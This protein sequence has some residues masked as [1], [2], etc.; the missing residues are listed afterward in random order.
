MIRNNID[1]VDAEKP[2][3]SAADFSTL[4]E[5]ISQ[6]L[7]IGLLKF[8]SDLK[9]TTCTPK[10]CE[11]IG[12]TTEVLHAY[13]NYMDIISHLVAECKSPK[14]A[15]KQ[16]ILS[17]IQT[18]ITTQQ[19][20][21]KKTPFQTHVI[22]KKG[23][24]LEFGQIFNADG[25]LTA[26]IKDK[27][28][29]NLQEDAVN[30]AMKIGRTGYWYFNFN[31]QDSH[32][33]GEYIRD[34]LDEDEI[35]QVREKGIWTIVH[36]EDRTRAKNIWKDLLKNPTLHDG[37][38]RI[39]TQKRGTTWLNCHVRPQLSKTN[40]MVGLICF[41]EDVTETLEIQTKL[42]T[43]KE[44]TEKI[45]QTKVDFL[46]RLS[47]EI[48]TPLNAVI[49]L[50]DTL[51]NDS[52]NAHLMPK[53][54]LIDDSAKHI[55]LLLNET[56]DHAK[57]EAAELKLDPHANSPKDV[58]ESTCRLWSYQAQKK[59]LKLNCHVD[60]SVPD[61]MLFD[62]HRYEQCLNNL[63]SNAIKFTSDGQINVVLTRFTQAGESDKLVLAVKDNGIGMSE[64]QQN[65][66][67]QAYV[68]ADDSISRRFGGTGLGLNI[69]KTIVELM[70]GTI[71]VESTLGKGALFIITLPVTPITDSLPDEE[72]SGLVSKIL[73]AAPKP[74]ASPYAHL[75]VLAVDD[76]ATNHFVVQSLL[77]THVYKIF[78]ANNG[79][80]ALDILDV[81]DIDIILM[82]IH[83]PVMDGVEATLAIRDSTRA[84]KDVPIIALTADPDYQQKRMCMNIGMN[85][86]LSK[87]VKFS[88]IKQAFETVLKTDQTL[89]IQKKVA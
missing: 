48:R 78:A 55:L 49:G 71:S 22:T 62:A 36:P 70:E 2:A 41:F 28:R 32:H 81:E 25:S 80:E 34:L 64:E 61:K 76:N 68:Q 5:N 73:E 72:T 66:V 57:L 16:S 20:S 30:A 53:L 3:I 37:V 39:R 9:L 79:Q 43:S 26:L 14:C 23:K 38:Y 85:Y 88:E 50:T 15:E 13:S 51:V 54:Q 33:N 69:T 10:A 83:M 74:E 12:L 27:S 67:F 7:D 47:H 40:D 17:R 6:I 35:I 60:A 65:K 44:E 42:K 58:V 29:E 84:W 86:A 56:L 87:P 24:Y 45:L 89:A 19:R 21:E 82:D 8:S 75:K 59:N 1:S 77:E 18:K 31:T 4:P 11:L 63:I 52:K 46:G